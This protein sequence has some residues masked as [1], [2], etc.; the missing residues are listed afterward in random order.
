MEVHE[1]VVL[2]G[3][4]IRYRHRTALVV[5]RR[6][7]RRL[8]VVGR[9]D[10]A[11][12][13]AARRDLARAVVPKVFHIAVPCEAVLCELIRDRFCGR[14]I[15]AALADDLRIRSHSGDGDVGVIRGELFVFVT[16]RAVVLI[17]A[18]HG[19][20][21]NQREIV[22][23][24][25]MARAVVLLQQR[26][27]AGDGLREIRRRHRGT[28]RTVERLVLEDDREHV[29][30]RRQPGRR[31]RVDPNRYGRRSDQRTR[32][33]HR[34]RANETAKQTGPHSDA[35]ARRNGHPR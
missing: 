23:Q 31:L 13:L 17:G 11:F 22:A 6:H 33:Q 30:D 4:L 7:L 1:R 3:V 24:T 5:R 12:G 27:V 19:L 35:F 21:A 32:G 2:G 28:E 25:E 16:R 8:R 29:P 15:D 10:A 14:R 26:A 18:R 9:T 34:A 20:A